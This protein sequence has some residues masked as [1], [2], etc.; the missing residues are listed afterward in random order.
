MDI[1][2][3]EKALKAADERGDEKEARQIAKAIQEIQTVT[4][5]S[6]MAPTIANLR[7]RQSGATAAQYMGDKAKAG[8]A[9]FAGLYNFVTDAATG[10]QD[11][12][13]MG[14]LAKTKVQNF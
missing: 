7:Q 10:G 8:V 14:D 13:A 5:A 2:G 11:P 4:E 6:G 3:L 12:N 1:T 9:G